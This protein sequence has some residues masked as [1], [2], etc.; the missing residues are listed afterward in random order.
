MFPGMA[1]HS[2]GVSVDEVAL[3]AGV[4]R[5]RR[6]PQNVM[7]DVGAHFGY[8]LERFLT[9]GWSVYAFEPDSENRSVLEAR[10][11][12]D[13]RVTID[14][15]ALSDQVQES[16]TLYR[17]PVST[18]ISTLE[19]FHEQHSP[20]EEVA[21][22][23]LRSAVSEY[24]IQHVTVLK[25]DAE[26]HDL[27]VLRGGDW[28]Q[29]PPEV[30][31]A[32]FDNKKTAV[33]GHAFEDLAEFLQGRGYQLLISE[34]HPVVEY[35]QRHRFRRLR[36][37]PTTLKDDNAWGNVIAVAPT[38]LFLRL[39]ARFRLTHFMIH[40]WRLAIRAFHRTSR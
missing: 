35:G 8:T 40:A 1:I 17:S 20:A 11:R 36:K 18:G 14:S 31:I 27:P 4:F 15:R 28:D 2:S 29:A 13:P 38:L 23:T 21:V 37:Y 3:V 7:I 9:L 6:G 39:H 5:R 19:P 32:E 34:W 12:S 24:G 25:V 33:V 22:T 26:G 16:A 10:Y 30:V